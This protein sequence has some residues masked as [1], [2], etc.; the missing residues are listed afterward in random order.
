VRRST[1]KRWARDSRCNTHRR[2]LNASRQDDALE[3]L[4]HEVLERTEWLEQLAAQRCH[5]P[6]RRA[7]R[8]A[9]GVSRRD[10]ADG[11]VLR[12]Q[13]RLIARAE[14]LPEGSGKL[15]TVY[16]ETSEESRRQNAASPA[17]VA[18]LV[19]G[20]ERSTSESNERWRGMRAREGLVMQRC[21][22]RESNPKRQYF[23]TR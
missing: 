15:G 9:R 1:T 19:Y 21:P 2:C 7:R 17:G 5:P 6:H 10:G 11:D 22:Q 18:F 8:G 23:L 3:V 16:S 13:T 20:A 4:V 14:E 12:L